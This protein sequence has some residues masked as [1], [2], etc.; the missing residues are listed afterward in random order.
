MA[1]P[2]SL[3]SYFWDVDPQAVDA[4]RNATFII[5]RI[6]EYG[7]T[8][9]IRWLARAFS[10]KDIINTMTASR[11]LSPRSANL[12]AILYNV[13]REQLRC[14]DPSFRTLHTTL[15]PH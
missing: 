3:S 5:E 13:P 10:Q 12:W 4:E 6:L 11:R 9:A 14:F 8:D 7:N 1:L 15:W 2:L